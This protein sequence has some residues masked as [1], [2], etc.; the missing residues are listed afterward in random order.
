MATKKTATIAQRK[1]LDEL[2]KMLENRLGEP[3]L[4]ALPFAV[5]C[6]DCEQ[7]RELTE[8]RERSSAQRRAV[9]ALLFD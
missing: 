3:R 6:K 2:R 7:I 4:R 5:R 1:R 9:S 8:Q